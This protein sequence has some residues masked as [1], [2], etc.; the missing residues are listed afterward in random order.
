MTNDHQQENC[1][2][3]SHTPASTGCIKFKNGNEPCVS[4]SPVPAESAP[5][6]VQRSLSVGET[7]ERLNKA[8]ELHFSEWEFDKYLRGM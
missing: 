7:I 5:G 2:N 4:G 1:R 3:C 8:V 6:E